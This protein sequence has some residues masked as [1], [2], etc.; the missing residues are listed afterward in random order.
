MPTHISRDADSRIIEVS[1]VDRVSGQ[2]LHDVAVQNIQLIEETGE[3]RNLIDATQ[4]SETGTILDIYLLPGRY[5]EKNLDR[6][7]R[8]AVVLPDGHHLEHLAEFYET[9][10]VNRGWQARR[11]SSH[12]AAL[13]WLGSSARLI[14]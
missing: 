8:F 4:L 13:T 5:K 14:N 1:L 3:M 10:C 11:F 2:E 12:S 9:V 6:R 7:A